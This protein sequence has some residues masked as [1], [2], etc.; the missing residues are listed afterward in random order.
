M[1]HHT[2]ADDCQVFLTTTPKDI[3]VAK[4]RVVD[5]IDDIQKWMLQ[6][7]LILNLGS[8]AKFILFAA[9]RRLHLTDWSPLQFAGEV[10]EPVNNMQL[11]VVM[12]N[13][14]LSLEGHIAILTKSCMYKLHR[15]REVR[16]TLPTSAVSYSVFST[17]WSLPLANVTVSFMVF[18]TT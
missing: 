4:D 8:K 6:N 16:K 5:C 2:C 11:L 12:L 17:Q 1:L 3:S 14:S 10:I 9:P 13:I 18:R 7:R 15:F